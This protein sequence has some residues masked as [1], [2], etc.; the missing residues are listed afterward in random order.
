MVESNSVSAHKYIN[1]STY[2]TVIGCFNG[3]YKRPRCQQEAC[4][5]PQPL[6]HNVGCA[7]EPPF[8]QVRREVSK[9]LAL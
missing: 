7:C 5:I 1:I 3:Y 9:V 8:R 2:C 6:H 4:E